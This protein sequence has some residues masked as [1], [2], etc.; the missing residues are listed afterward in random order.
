MVGGKALEI[1]PDFGHA[2]FN[3]GTVYEALGQVGEA[4][5]YYRKYLDNPKRTPG[6]DEALILQ[7]ISALEAEVSSVSWSAGKLKKGR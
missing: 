6:L 4:I 1:A 5:K 2:Q 3:L 7:R